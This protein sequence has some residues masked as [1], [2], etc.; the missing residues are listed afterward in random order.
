[1]VKPRLLCVVVHH[2]VDHFGA[3]RRAPTD[4]RG[5]EVVRVG[6][7]G[8]GR[9]DGGGGQRHPRDALDDGQVPV[10][11]VRE[12]GPLGAPRRGGDGGAADP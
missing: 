3:R 9:A 2:L 11:A 5:P 12:A 8:A 6:G 10:G 4:Q 1:M 7:A